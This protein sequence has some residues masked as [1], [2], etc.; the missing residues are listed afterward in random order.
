MDN[1][2][3]IGEDLELASIIE[4]IGSKSAKRKAASQKKIIF[5]EIHRQNEDDG[6]NDLTA[7]E[8]LAELLGGLTVDELLAKLSA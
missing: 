2:Q 8:L 1:M 4:A 5:A 7:G 6:L 3:Q